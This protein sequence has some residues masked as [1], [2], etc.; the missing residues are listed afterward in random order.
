M[1]PLNTDRE[2][3]LNLK[4]TPP[5]AMGRDRFSIAPIIWPEL[6]LE[7]RTG[8]VRTQKYHLVLSPQQARRHLNVFSPGVP[9]DIYMDY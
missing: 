4:L 2:Q 7:P 6:D 9:R 8:L 5:Q 1:G 3:L